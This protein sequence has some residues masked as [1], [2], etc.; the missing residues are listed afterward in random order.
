VVASAIAFDTEQER[1]RLDGMFYSEI[2]EKSSYANLRYNFV[3]DLL[4][5]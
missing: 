3:A 4:E 1:A 2:D 5:N